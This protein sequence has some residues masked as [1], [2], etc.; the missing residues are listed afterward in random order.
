MATNTN[1]TQP[2][3]TPKEDI[4]TR[5]RRRLQEYSTKIQEYDKLDGE[6]NK[7]FGVSVAQIGGPEDIV[8]ARMVAEAKNRG[9]K[10]KE[11]AVTVIGNP[12]NQNTCLAGV[13]T[14]ASNAGVSFNKMSGNLQSGLGT[15]KQGR[16]IPQYNPLFTSQLSNTGYYELQPGEKPKPGDLV[17]YF[18]PKRSGELTPYHMEFITED[19]GGNKYG[20]FNNYRLFNDGASESEVEDVRDTDASNKGRSSNLNRFYR[21]TPEAAKA[22]AG[23]E[24]IAFIDSGKKLRAELADLRESAIPGESKDVFIRIFNG[25]KMNNKFK[26]EVLQD[27]LPYAK[28]KEMVKSVIDELYRTR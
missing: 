1:G 18:E 3:P 5:V 8:A 9:S 13:C 10:G 28:N 16:K 14:I 22:A 11:G 15:D 21:L 27:V 6:F 4:V 20:T 2:D 23:E 24:S 25:L 7:R 19:K 26:W 17:Q 12:L